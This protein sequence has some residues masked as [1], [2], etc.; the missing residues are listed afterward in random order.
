ML[1]IRRVGAFILGFSPL[2]AQ[3]LLNSFLA[4][5]TEN[6]KRLHMNDYSKHLY[7]ILI[8]DGSGPFRELW[9]TLLEGP[10]R[11]VEVC[12]S[13]HAAQDF[14]R[15][16]PVDVAILHPSRPGTS[17]NALARQIIDRNPRAQVVVCSNHIHQETG[18]EARVLRLDQVNHLHSNACQVLHLAESSKLE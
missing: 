15:Y 9:R 16:Y 7:R 4:D 12:D 13:V 11:S 5:E 14:V 18:E 1:G 6:K 17:V 3:P 2:V 8:V 10:D